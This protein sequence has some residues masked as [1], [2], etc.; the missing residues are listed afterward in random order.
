MKKFLL[1][2]LMLTLFAAGSASAQQILPGISV[3]NYRGKILISWKNTYKLPV[4]NINIQRSYDSL[5]NYTTIGSVLN[6][7]NEENGYSDNEP[8]YNK[9]YYRVFIAFEGGSYIISPSVRPVKA[10]PL[11]TS[12]STTTDSTK[13]DNRLPWQL[14][15]RRDS[16]YQ[17]PPPPP[18]VKN[19]VVY[20]SLRI[21]TG[22]DNNI[23]IHLPDAAI[24]KYTAKFFNDAEKQIFELTTLKDEY[25][26]LEKVNFGHAGWYFFELYEDGKLLEKNKFLVP[27]D[28]RINN[29]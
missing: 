14:D 26:I 17:A 5:K 23:I 16:T 2:V 20:P 24:K 13:T 27:K 8:P 28:G 10:L 6:P 19:E 18:V 9:M 25:L 3:T 4:S 12:D 22:R 15:P 29:R 11:P 7:Q 1:I 21:F